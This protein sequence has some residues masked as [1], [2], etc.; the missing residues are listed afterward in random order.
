MGEERK[1]EGS[2]LGCA[3]CIES[4]DIYDHW[5]Y[6]VVVHIYFW[7][8]GRKHVITSSSIP[9]S[10]IPTNWNIFVMSN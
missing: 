6:L 3:S 5:C 2:S 10:S 4:L 9:S 1:E 7:L 8:C